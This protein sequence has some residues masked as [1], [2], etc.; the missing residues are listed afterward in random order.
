MLAVISGRLY[1]KH[2]D[3]RMVYTNTLALYHPIKFVSVGEARKGAEVYL[4]LLTA[5]W[6]FS[7]A[8]AF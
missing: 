7:C 6:D 3:N 2:K 4:W 1:D 5:N 8:A